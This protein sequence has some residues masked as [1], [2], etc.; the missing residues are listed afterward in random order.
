MAQKTIWTTALAAAAVAIVAVGG[1]WT[2][3]N[4][5]LREEH[6]LAITAYLD[7]LNKYAMAK[8]SGKLPSGE[9]MPSGSE[10]CGSRDKR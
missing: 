5:L 1:W 2:A 6:E 3:Q 8:A 4:S 7:C 10:V 9:P